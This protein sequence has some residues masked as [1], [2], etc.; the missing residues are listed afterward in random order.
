M[1]LAPSS[2]Q[3]G[4]LWLYLHCKLDIGFCVLVR[5]KHDGLVWKLP[6]L[7]QRGLHLRKVAREHPAAAH[8][9]ESI[10]RQDHGYLWEKVCDVGR[11]V[12][13]NFEHTSSQRAT[14]DF[15]ALT[16]LKVNTWDRLILQARRWIRPRILTVLTAMTHDLDIWKLS[17]EIQITS[18][19]VTVI[20][21][22]QDVGQ[23]PPPA[24]HRACN[25]PSLWSVHGDGCSRAFVVNHRAI[26]V[27]EARNQLHL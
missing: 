18:H 25:R 3:C 7:A 14:H 5:A 16:H 11:R 9:K 1:H 20:V 4:I 24:S 23:C 26:V 17:L 10:P 2:K 13:A 6:K 8:S 15:R 27:A 12:T 21:G 19:M 22:V